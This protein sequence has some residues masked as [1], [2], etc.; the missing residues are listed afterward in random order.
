MFTRKKDME[1]TAHREQGWSIS[2][3]ARHLGRSRETVRKQLDGTR[4]AGERR[5]SGTLG[6]G[7]LTIVQRA[8][9]PRR[10]PWAR[11]P[12]RADL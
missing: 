11:L 3:I 6:D 1:A 4:P 2:A 12:S 8:S 9:D 5:R 7:L 10:T